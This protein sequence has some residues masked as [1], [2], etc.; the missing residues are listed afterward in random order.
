V[1]QADA[2]PVLAPVSP[3]LSP[4]GALARAARLYFA[5]GIAGVLILITGVVFKNS[6]IVLMAGPLIALTQVPLFRSIRRVLPSDGQF[7][8]RAVMP[9]GFVAV[10]ASLGLTTA[11]LIGIDVLFFSVAGGLLTGGW[12]VL[13]G[14]SRPHLPLPLPRRAVVGGLGGMVVSVSF[15][16]GLGT[17]AWYAATFVGGI[18]AISALGFVFGLLDLDQPRTASAQ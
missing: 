3:E 1:D 4:Y 11:R 17:P 15:L 16:F 10:A 18:L 12:Y 2:L 9:V 8:A 7:A 13:V 6:T 5:G 14:L